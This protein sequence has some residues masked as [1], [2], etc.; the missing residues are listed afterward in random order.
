MSM[1]SQRKPSFHS[2]NSKSNNKKQMLHLKNHNRQNSNYFSKGKKRKHKPSNMGKSEISNSSHIEEI[3]R[4]HEV[5]KDM[6][7]IPIII[8]TSK[9][10][11][12]L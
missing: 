10:I 2:T 7:T 5:L 8:M 11:L 1:T 9:F 3:S 12:S 6:F 4:I